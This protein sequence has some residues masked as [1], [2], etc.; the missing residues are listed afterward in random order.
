MSINRRFTA[1]P[2]GLGD[3]DWPPAPTPAQVSARR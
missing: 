3:S 1:P 2:L